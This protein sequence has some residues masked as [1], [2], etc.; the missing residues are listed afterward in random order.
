MTSLYTL[1]TLYPWCIVC[2]MEI[3]PFPVRGSSDVSIDIFLYWSV[4]NIVIDPDYLRFEWRLTLDQGIIKLI[5][6]RSWNLYWHWF[7]LVQ[8]YVSIFISK[9]TFSLILLTLFFASCCIYWNQ[10]ISSSY[11]QNKKF[12]IGFIW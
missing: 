5:S 4:P 6:S 11:K 3:D 12:E 10:C 1:N 7:C 2:D 8:I 9:V